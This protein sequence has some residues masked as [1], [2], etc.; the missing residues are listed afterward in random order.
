MNNKF[1]KET[2]SKA[3]QG[4]VQGIVELLKKLFRTTSA[5]SPSKDDEMI[6]DDANNRTYFQMTSSPVVAGEKIPFS[7]PLSST[8]SEKYHTSKENYHQLSS[9]DCYF[10]ANEYEQ[11]DEWN[12]NDE[13]GHGMKSNPTTTK[14]SI[15]IKDF[16]PTPTNNK[17][18]IP[19]GSPDS[20]YNAD[21]SFDDETSSN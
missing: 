13:E 16:I 14:K 18:K 17:L 21:L 10:T 6:V 20:G 8:S 12:D 4:F 1:W 7:S 11:D 2:L 15:L 9:P 3:F 19:F 5:D